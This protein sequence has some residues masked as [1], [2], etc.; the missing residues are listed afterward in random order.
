MAQGLPDKAVE[1]FPNC[2]QVYTA[3]SQEDPMLPPGIWA[4]LSQRGLSLAD[5]D[6]EA[7][8]EAGRSVIQNSA[9]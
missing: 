8:L 9:Y 1:V 7:G 6:L 5:D 3:E 4:S 2:L